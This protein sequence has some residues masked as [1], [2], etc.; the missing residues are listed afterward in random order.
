[1]SQNRVTATRKFKIVHCRDCGCD[2]R[3][4]S[5]TRTPKRCVECGVKAVTD[6]CNQISNKSGPVYEKR[7]AGM[8]R[9][10][11]IEARRGVVP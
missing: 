9:F 11:A 5:N 4:G 1:M 6:A 7:L 2:M 8:A 3:V 10:L